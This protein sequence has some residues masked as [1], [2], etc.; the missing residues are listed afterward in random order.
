MLWNSIHKHRRGEFDTSCFV[1]RA[2]CIESTVGGTATTPTSHGNYEDATFLIK[3][4]SPDGSVSFAVRR[5]VWQAGEDMLQGHT[6]RGNEDAPLITVVPTVPSPDADA[7]TGH[8][9]PQRTTLLALQEFTTNVV[10]LSLW[11]IGAPP[12]AGGAVYLPYSL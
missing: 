6:C 2:P 9:K 12:F 1:T 11:A 5:E 3:L 8:N 4:P 7:T 10:A